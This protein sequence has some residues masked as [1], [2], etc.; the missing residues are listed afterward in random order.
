MPVCVPPLGLP[1][2][3]TTLVVLR[4]ASR[5]SGG[6]VDLDMVDIHIKD[7]TAMLLNHQ[8]CHLA[9]DVLLRV[10]IPLSALWSPERTLS[11]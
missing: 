1:F 2:C 7:T 9:E 8:S 11:R 5:W 6:S 4:R 10:L 3:L